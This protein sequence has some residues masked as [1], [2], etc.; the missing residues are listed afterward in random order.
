MNIQG[1][2]GVGIV[3]AMTIRP[4]VGGASAKDGT[5]EIDVEGDC[6]GRKLPG[7]EIADTFSVS[8]CEHVRDVDV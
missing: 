6:R 2:Q 4:L 3:C 1:A 7:K 8:S 5:I